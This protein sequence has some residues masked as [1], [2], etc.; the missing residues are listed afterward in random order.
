MNG[1]LR[2]SG[3]DIPPIRPIT[4][5]A[6]AA[7]GAPSSSD[8]PVRARTTIRDSKETHA[9]ERAIPQRAQSSPFGR[10]S[11]RAARSAQHE[12]RA[13]GDRARRA[14]EGGTPSPHPRTEAPV[15]PISSARRGARCLRR[16]ARRVPGGPRALEMG[17]TGADHV[18]PPLTVLAGRRSGS[19]SRGRRALRRS[20]P[21]SG[22]R[23]AAAYRSAGIGLHHRG[24]GRCPRG[25]FH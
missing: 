13:R 19:S 25:R 24:G 22:A 12:H 3:G 23:A 21:G 1:Q 9:R 2:A 20:S 8:F 11:P 17:A 6:R 5:R 4:P 10:T 16:A 7:P 15:A 18:E 14:R